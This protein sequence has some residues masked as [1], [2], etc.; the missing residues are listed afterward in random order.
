M[1]FNS[2]SDITHVPQQLDATLFLQILSKCSDRENHS[3]EPYASHAGALNRWSAP[4]ITLIFFAPRPSGFAS[5]S[6]CHRAHIKQTG[7]ATRNCPAR[8]L[9]H[10]AA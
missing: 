9:K 5:Q 2:L 7:S 1:M 10:F 6:G 3:Q 4:G 8:K